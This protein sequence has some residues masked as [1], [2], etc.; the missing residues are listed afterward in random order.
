M[1][2]P[3]KITI[4]GLGPLTNFALLYKLFPED[5]PNISEIYLMGGSY[6]AVGN[7]SKCAEFNF[8]T[9]PESA[10]IVFDETKSPV[11]LVPWEVCLESSKMMDFDQFRLVEMNVKENPFTKLLDPIEIK[12]Y[13]GVHMVNNDCANILPNIKVIFFRTGFHVMHLLLLLSLFQE[14]LRKSQIFMPPLN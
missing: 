9:D 13:Q 8:Y 7:T 10:R 12:T 2:Y 3:H 5:I 11:Y 1:Q 14:S 4:I 6:Q